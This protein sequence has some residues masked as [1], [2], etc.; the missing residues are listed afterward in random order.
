[1]RFLR[2]DPALKFNATNE[3]FHHGIPDFFVSFFARK[4]IFFSEDEGPGI[5]IS[6]IFD[7][8]ISGSVIID[9]IKYLSAG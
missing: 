6:N 1:M 2:K 5:L 7:S 4:N 3:V 9:E 8:Q